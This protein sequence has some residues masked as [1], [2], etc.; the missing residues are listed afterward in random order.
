MRSAE[1]PIPRIG[2]GYDVHQLVTG[3]PLVLGGVAIAHTHGL[4]G[5]SDADVLIHA[6]MDALLG[7]AALGDIGKHFP[8]TDPQYRGISSVRLLAHV[9]ELLASRGYALVNIDATLILEAPKILPHVPQM[10]ANIGA[11]LGVDPDR[12]SIKAT[13][14]EAMGFVGRREGAAAHAV[15]AILQLP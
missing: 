7:A 12:I 10:Q 15:A 3:R 14:G 6:I 8:N 1:H 11:A 13:T 4:D 2:F 5:H 9:G